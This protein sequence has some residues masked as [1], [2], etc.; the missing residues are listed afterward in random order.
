MASDAVLDAKGIVK[1]FGAVRVLFGVDFDV[2][3]GE[4][5]ALIGENGAGKSTLVKIVCGLLAPTAGELAYKGRPWRPAS[6]TWRS[7]AA[8]SATSCGPRPAPPSTG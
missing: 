4:V 2:R 5:H 8:A 1:D 7:A 3:R 6:G